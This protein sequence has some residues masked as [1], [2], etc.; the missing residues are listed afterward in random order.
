MQYRMHPKDVNKKGAGVS[1]KRRIVAAVSALVVGLVGAVAVA[2]PA[3]AGS[4]RYLIKLENT[5]YCAALPGYPYGAGEQLQLENC[6][7]APSFTFIDTGYASFEYW[8]RVDYSGY[9]VQAGV[10]TLLNSTLIQW[11]FCLCGD[12]IWHLV[13][14]SNG[15]VLIQNPAHNWWIMQAESASLYAY[16]RYAYV[17]TNPNARMRWILVPA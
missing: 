5:N 15:A 3:H 14:A 16:I 6:A 9:Y 17:D 8:L 7:Y 1:L 13:G 11:P 10:P 4:Y 2:A 12:Q